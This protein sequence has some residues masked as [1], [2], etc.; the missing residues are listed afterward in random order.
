[1][2]QGTRALRQQLLAMVNGFMLSQALYAFTEL[3]LADAIGDGRRTPAELAPEVGADP[4][5]LNRLLRALAAAGV[6]DEDAQ[7]G[8]ALTPLG[9]GLRS[10]A[11][12]SLAGWTALAG[13]ENFW[14]NW[15]GLVESVRTG[16]TGWSLR[17]GVTPWDYRATH[18]DASRLFDRGMVSITGASADTVAEDYDFSRFATVVDVGGGRGTLLSQILRRHSGVRGVLF[19]LPHVID[20]ASQLLEANDVLDRCRIAG[21]SFFES[22]PEGGDAYVLKSVLHDWY[23]PEA[24]R[25]LTTVRRAI[26]SAAVL[27][28]VERILDPPNQG[29]VGK[30]G[31][32]NMLVNP[33]GTERNLAE[34]ERLLHAG[35]FRLDKVHPTAGVYSILEA[36]PA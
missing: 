33:G 15:G 30:L 27:L 3:G 36:L 1:M 29:L 17:L 18:P 11:P 25:I 26:R 21:G 35:G 34:W 22:V 5:A 6:L 23:D 24:L 4:G 8:F 2:T 13:S 16:K 31:D 32:L 12:G 7:S 14:A 19:D 20:G 10:D 28:V 9:E